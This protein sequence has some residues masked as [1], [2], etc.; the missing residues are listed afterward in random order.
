VSRKTEVREA[1][2]SKKTPLA[3]FVYNRPGHTRRALAAIAR[4]QRLSEVTLHVFSDAPKSEKHAEAVDDVRG[5]ICAFALAPPKDLTV[6][7]VERERNLGLAGSI[8]GSVTALTRQYGQVI[9]LEDDLVPTPDFLP[10]MLDGLKRYQDDPRVMQISGCLLP[11]RLQTAED[12]FFL[13]LTTTWGWATWK[14]AWSAFK[15]V[16]AADRARLE[17]DPALRSRFTAEGRFDYVAMLDDRLAGRNDSWGIQWW[18]AVAKAAGLVL[19]P[20]ESLIWNG[21]FDASGVHC[22]GTEVFQPD[23]P[24][25]FAAPRLGGEM[26]LPAKVLIDKNSWAKV[27]SFLEGPTRPQSRP[28]REKLFA[29]VKSFRT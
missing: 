26:R 22:G 17:T 1:L 11:G 8:A 14:R 13:P 10:F 21:G 29:L 3:L 19:Y 2:V 27:L 5:L 24:P 23:P 4:L 12:G 7:L 16:D 6:H 18:Y 20:R 25:Q 15:P 9:V 28:W